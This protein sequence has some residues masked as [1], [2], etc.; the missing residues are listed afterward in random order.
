L[1]VE[2]EVQDIVRILFRC[3]DGEVLFWVKRD[4]F[5]VCV[6]DDILSLFGEFQFECLYE[7]VPC[8]LCNVPSVMYEVDEIVRCVRQVC[9]F[10]ALS[11]LLEILADI[12]FDERLF[13]LRCDQLFE[14]VFIWLAMRPYGVLFIH[15]VIRQAP[16][17]LICEWAGEFGR[18]LVDLNDAIIDFPDHFD[19]VWQVEV[20]I[21]ARPPGFEP[22]GEFLELPCCLPEYLRFFPGDPEWCALAWERL[23]NQKGATRRFTEMGGEKR[24]VLK[25]FDD[26]GLDVSQG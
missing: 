14:P 7:F 21:Q 10:C 16:T 5:F 20:I 24:R 19:Q 6:F 4:E 8:F 18:D 26:Q 23:G 12:V 22:Y 9:R 17:C 15:F 2:L 25:T 3:L 11:F 13:L 1:V